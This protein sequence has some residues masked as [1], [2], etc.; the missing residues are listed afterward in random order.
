MEK[1]KKQVRKS[2]RKNFL[3]ET[4]S[5]SW[6]YIKES[7]NFIL[8]IILIY[9]WA[10]IIAIYY[11]PPEIANLI[12]EFLEDL[13]KRTEGLGTG[14]TI[15]FILDNNFKSSFWA[16]VLGVFLGIFPVLIS[17]AN[18]Y[19]LGFVAEKAVSRE[20]LLSLWRLLPHGIFE[21]PALFISLGLGTRLGFFIFA[22]NKKAEFLRRVQESL[23]VF[24][25]V[26][27]PLLIIASII[28]GILIYLVG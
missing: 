21:I 20:G 12:I 22:K 23:R 27:L 8:L 14:E 25:F 5:F 28:E 16:L 13:L 17:F 19:V 7:K 15:L 9:L 2:R 3:V 26:I 10:F 4:Y 24:L 18:G 11:H 1:Q 6:K